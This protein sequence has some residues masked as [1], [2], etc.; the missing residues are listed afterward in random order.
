[1][2]DK[3]DLIALVKGS[4]VPYLLMNNDI[5]KKAGIYRGGFNN[6][7]KWNYDLTELSE[8]DLFYIYT[9][10]KKYWSQKDKNNG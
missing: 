5:I 9:I 3:Y 10:I 2:Y 1:M 6:E 4:S 8:Q 7:W